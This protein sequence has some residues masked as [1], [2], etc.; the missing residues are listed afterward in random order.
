ME[1]RWSDW[2]FQHVAEHGVEPEEA[3]EVVSGAESPWPL[4]SGDGK[5]LVWG[6]GRGDRPLQVVFVLDPDDTIYIIHARPLTEREKRRF[7]R[8]T[9]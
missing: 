3:E 7:R 2:N 1:F 9:T 6:R 8:R 4:I 5:Y